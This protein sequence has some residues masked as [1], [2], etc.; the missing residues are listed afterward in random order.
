MVALSPDY[1]T[2]YPPPLPLHAFLP[3]LQRAAPPSL[4]P[5]QL[6]HRIAPYTE[7]HMLLARDLC[8]DTKDGR[9]I[10]R[11]IKR[12]KTT[13]CSGNLPKIFPVK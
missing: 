2:L 6:H 3:K 13:G 12:E 7:G 1:A 9:A 4:E 11:D 8:N 5:P 10:H